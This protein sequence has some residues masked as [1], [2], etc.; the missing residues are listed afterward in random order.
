MMKN[1]KIYKF[2]M[3][4]LPIIMLTLG[5][6]Y[7]SVAYDLTVS[8]SV[9]MLPQDE[10]AIT[11]V[12]PTNL[13][14]NY[15]NTV[16]TTNLELTNGSDIKTLSVTIKNLGNSKQIFDGIIYDDTQVVLYSNPNIIPSVSGITS[17]STILNSHGNNDDTITFSLNFGYDDTTNITDNVLNGTVN[18]HFTPLREVTYVN[19]TN[20]NGLSNEYIRSKPFTDMNNNTFSNSVTIDSST[21]SI[22]ISTISDTDLVEGVDY[23]FTNGVVT[24]LTELNQ[25]IIIKNAS[26]AY[27]MPFNGT[28]GLFGFNKTNITEFSRN[29]T[30]TESQVTAKSGVINIKNVSE[31]EYNSAYDIY[32]WVENNKFYWWSEADT[33]YFHPDTVKPFYSYTNL[34]TV[35]LNGTSTELVTN[36]AHWFDTSR[37]LKEIIGKIKTDGL[38]LEYN[39]SFNY[40]SDATENTSA[41][42]GF[43]FMFNDCNALQ[44]VD[45]S[46]FVTHNATDM[47]R[48]FGG[49][50][51]LTN[52]D[53]SHFDTSNVR[54]MYWMF[55]KA[56]SLKT[57]DLSSF[58]TS[59]VINMKE[60][61]VSATGLQ[62]LFLGEDFDTSNVARFTGAFSGM[63]NL[64][65]IY[66]KR[67]FV[68]SASATA[69]KLFTSDTKL[70]GAYGQSYQV[71]YSS[72]NVDVNY[73][74][75]ATADQ[76]GYFTLYKD[77]PYYTITYNLSGGTFPTNPYI[78]FESDPNLTLRQPTKEGYKFVGWTGSNGNTPE[79]NVVI[80]SGSTGNK[81]YTAN[82]ALAEYD[83]IYDAN[84]GS[85]QMDDRTLSYNE[86][87]LL[88]ANAYTREG[89]KF[90]S[91][92]TKADG[93]GTEYMNKQYITNIT[94]SSSITLYAQWVS[95]NDLDFNKVFNVA[96]PC[97]FNGR[98]TNITGDCPD[99]LNTNHINTGIRLY[100]S[101]NYSKDYVIYFKI[102]EYNISAQNSET[103]Q[104]LMNSKYELESAGYPGIVFRR[105]SANKF[106]VTITMNSNRI[107]AEFIVSDVSTVKIIRRNGKTYYSINDN[108]IYLLQDKPANT[109][110]FNTP[111]TFGASLQNGNENTPFRFSVAKLSNMY[112]KLGS[113]YEE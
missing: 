103:Q 106:E 12:T 59:N 102:D 85:G 31:D 55:R 36:F 38:R 19:C 107:N 90:V 35:N 17:N 68:K 69:G 54:S 112:I 100:D 42:V 34:V 47:K 74:K 84:G 37:K 25:D 96:G 88:D 52:L 93:T 44:S 22:I 94:E 21:N 78:Y 111:V 43:T 87:A 26:K 104:A 76:R 15:N 50:N 33:A 41:N 95:N 89:Y 2:V 110:T 65:A 9:A 3:I 45:L 109:E 64:T 91:W 49:C 24:F 18:L 6:G 86:S 60:M 20:S 10:V 58:D 11:N 16:L 46:G 105:T 75:I 80:P 70:V 39:N 81:T 23:T 82:Y 27:F 92:N 98:D 48:M 51:K 77:E 28:N 29:T 32:G 97:M 66:A 101:T 7:A 8:G 83:V 61:F 73:A 53:L 57:L 67:D 99:Y 5:I 30:L 63:T 79:K 40:A 13:V 1:K 56:Y 14:E 62:T 108:G 4:Y 113:Y 71:N 72:S